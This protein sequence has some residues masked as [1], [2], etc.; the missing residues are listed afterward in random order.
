MIP[1][2]ELKPF[3][4]GVIQIWPADVPLVPAERFL[5]FV[6]QLVARSRPGLWVL[7]SDSALVTANL[8][9]SLPT[10]S[11]SSYKTKT[12]HELEITS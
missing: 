8:N 4:C 9:K 1:E 12:T 2:Q 5:C 7:L 10:L 11:Q 6:K 3:G